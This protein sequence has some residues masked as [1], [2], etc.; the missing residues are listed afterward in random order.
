[1]TLTVTLTVILDSDFDSDFDNDFNYLLLSEGVAGR[2]LHVANNIEAWDV[3]LGTS[4]LDSVSLTS[5]QWTQFFDSLD[6]WS[7]T[8]TEAVKN[9]GSSVLD[10]SQKKTDNDSNMWVVR[11]SRLPPVS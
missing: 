8:L 1:M 9:I 7:V 5:Q 10:S 6:D 4:L 11:L 3:R 2:L